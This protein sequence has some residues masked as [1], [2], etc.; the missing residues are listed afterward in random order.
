MHSKFQSH[1][2]W[3]SLVMN[4]SYA[5][6]HFLPVT[7]TISKLASWE[8]ACLVSWR[9][10]TC[11]SCTVRGGSMY[12]HVHVEV[13][14]NVKCGSEEV[15]MHVYVEVTYMHVHVEVTYMHVHVEVT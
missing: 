9:L 12:M 7:A 3:Q 11:I 13:T 8:G 4:L 15:Y 5:N 10:T 1:S 14:Y 6:V 2:Y